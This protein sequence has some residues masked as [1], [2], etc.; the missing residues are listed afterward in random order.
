[1]ARQK[2]IDYARNLD[3]ETLI[4]RKSWASLEEMEQVIPYHTPKFEYVVK[5][6]Q[7]N[8]RIPSINELSFTTRFMASFLF[9]RVKASRPA[10]FRYLTLSMI[11]DSKTKGG[12]VHQT[13]FKTAEK[14]VFDT[15]ILTDEVLAVIDIYV[16]V[17]R[18]L[19]SPKCDYL[20]ITTKGTPY[21]ALGNGMSILT[22]QAIG[23]TVNPTRYRMIIETES[24]TN[25][26]DSEQAAISRDQKHSSGN[27]F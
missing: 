8:E 16:N 1:M 19:M 4:A 13:S 5:C 9:L 25:L 10:S 26:T 11:E 24:A 22:L 7:K 21:T 6:C 20:L 14:Y 17:L 2:K 15:L 12:V 3:L 23:K 27:F 18:P